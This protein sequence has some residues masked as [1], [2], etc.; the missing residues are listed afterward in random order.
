MDDT[1]R[2]IAANLRELADRLEHDPALFGVLVIG[3]VDV[4]DKAATTRMLY[5]SRGRAE[6]LGYAHQALH[7]FHAEQ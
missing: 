3:G 4:G 1:R 6:M 2:A 5:S 7:D